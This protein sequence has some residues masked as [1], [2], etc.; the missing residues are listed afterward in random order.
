MSWRFFE[1]Q[2]RPIWL[3]FHNVTHEN[4]QYVDRFINLKWRGSLAEPGS[5]FPSIIV[6][7]YS[8]DIIAGSASRDLKEKR[9]L[10]MTAARERVWSRE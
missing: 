8:R 3:I 2:V 5:V 7:I 4:I 6:F 1:A 10:I 9:V